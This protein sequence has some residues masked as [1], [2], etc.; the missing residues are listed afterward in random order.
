METIDEPITLQDFR[1]CYRRLKVRVIAKEQATFLQRTGIW[2]REYPFSVKV[3]GILPHEAEW[4]VMWA[5]LASLYKSVH[6]R[7]S[8][9][10]I[11]TLSMTWCLYRPSLI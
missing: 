1:K 2:A 6:S 8:G 5:D 10:E 7:S 3:K 11:T 9:L 4:T